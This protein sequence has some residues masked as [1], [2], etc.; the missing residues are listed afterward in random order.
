MVYNVSIQIDVNILKIFL[1]N[2]LELTSTK[3]KR[4]ETNFVYA[5]YF[6]LGSQCHEKLPKFSGLIYFFEI[7]KQKNDVGIVLWKPLESDGTKVLDLTG[8]GNHG[9][10]IGSFNMNFAYWEPCLFGWKEEGRDFVYKQV[11]EEVAL[12]LSNLEVC[13]FIDLSQSTIRS[14]ELCAN[15]ATFNISTGYVGI[16]VEV[17]FQDGS[18]TQNQTAPF[19]LGTSDWTQKCVVGIGWKPIH[20]VLLTLSSIHP[21]YYS[22]SLF[23]DISFHT[24]SKG[25]GEYSP[26]CNNPTKCIIYEQNPISLNRYAKAPFFHISQWNGRVSF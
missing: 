22:R 19:H 21:P 3:Y 24:S 18:Y 10:I 25:L 23:K 7:R 4:L 17:L 20:S 1:N 6:F 8:N 26:N 15:V 5:V 2:S 14:F 12:I 16:S 11:K 9:Q 13:K